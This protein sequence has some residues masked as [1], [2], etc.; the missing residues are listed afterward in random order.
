MNLNGRDAI[1]E[2]MAQDYERLKPAGGYRA[3][4]DE[5]DLSTGVTWNMINTEGYWPKDKMI[6]ETIEAKASLRGIRISK[7]G[8]K[9]DFLSDVN[10]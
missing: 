6:K 9:R 10:W 2:L 8:R 5:W 3:V 7:R 4:A 1:R